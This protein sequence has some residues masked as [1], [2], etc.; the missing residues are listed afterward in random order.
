[1]MNKKIEIISMLNVIIILIT[2]IVTICGICSFNTEFSYN[3]VNQYGQ[4]IQMWGTGVYAHDSFFKTPI[5]IGSDFTILTGILPLA[6]LVFLKMQL[7][8]K[9][10]IFIQNLAVMSIL[11]YYTA[12][13][14]FGVTYNQLHLLYIALFAACFYC[15]CF[16]FAK[17]NVAQISQKKVC[18]YNIPKGVN[19][20][21]VMSGIALF[22][23][24]LPDI[25]TSLFNGTSLDL[26]EVY[27]TEITY[28]LD[29]GIISP[30]M[31]LT[32]YLIN[33]GSF[34]GYVLLRMI[35]K[36]CIGV[37]IMLPIQTVFQMIAGIS[38]PIPALVTKML[39]F[40]ILALFAAFFE[41]RLKQKTKYIE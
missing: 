17:L 29:M 10:E 35:L 37:G 38:L 18:E 32:L 23:A 6:V 28:V 21:L 13:I 4:S 11:L 16:L 24:W 19:T 33:Q 5:F 34:I 3:T 14:A 25:L 22:V 41:Y 31:F 36:V 8:P 12:S 1:M 2:A 7:K 15:V 9:L 27:T 30:L 40:V 26:I 39:I 20:Y